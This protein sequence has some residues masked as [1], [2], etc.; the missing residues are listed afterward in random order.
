MVPD[1]DLGAWYT[2]FY[3]M[4]DTIYEASSEAGIT[5]REFYKTIVYHDAI[6][7]LT[8]NLRLPV[9]EGGQEWAIEVADHHR[10]AEFLDYYENQRPGEDERYW[11]LELIVASLDEYLRAD[12]P[13]ERLVA[14]V[15]HHLIES[16]EAHRDTVDYWARRTIPED[17]HFAIVSFMREMQHDR[18]RRGT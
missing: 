5:A 6:V 11:L 12:A 16:F 3:K 14:R 9:T 18:T 8:V 13:D 10:L 2:K 4:R 7:R 15:R 1:R 17:G